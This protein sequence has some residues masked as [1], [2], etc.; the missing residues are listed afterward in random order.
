LLSFCGKWEVIDRI[1]TLNLGVEQ[2]SEIRLRAAIEQS[3]YACSDRG[4]TLERKG[5]IFSAARRLIGPTNVPTES[6]E[7]ALE[8]A[9]NET[10][11]VLIK[12]AG[13]NYLQAPGMRIME[14]YCAQYINNA[15]N[16]PTDNQRRLFIQDVDSLI[17]EFEEIEK[18]ST[19]CPDFQLTNE[20]RKA[21]KISFQNRFSV[22][23]GGAG[24]GK[25]TV[26][27]ALYFLMDTIGLPRFQM[28]LSGM[29][30]ARMT[31]ATHE[32]ATTIAK[33]LIA[34]S[35][36][37]MGS[38]PIII[39][40]ECSMV[41]IS[42]FYRILNKV[43][44]EAH[45]VMVGDP[46]Q[47]PPI[48]AGLVL[49]CLYKIKNI[50]LT[51]LKVVK[52]QSKDSGILE[53]ASSVRLGKVPCITSVRSEDVIWIH[54]AS[55]ESGL[56][57]QVLELYEIDKKNTQILSATKTLNKLIN[58]IAHETYTDRNNT[59]DFMNNR[60]DRMEDSGFRLDDLIMF[61]KNDWQRDIQNGLLGQIVEVYNSPR[62][63]DLPGEERPAVSYGKALV[64]KT[65]VVELTERELMFLSHAYSITV[66]KSQG[67]QFRRVIVPL[68]RSKLLDRT[69]I[70]TAI[71]RATDKVV[72]IGDKKEFADS[73][74]SEPHAFFRQVG[75]HDLLAEH[76]TQKVD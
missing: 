3:V 62:Q 75:L 6:L 20:Q 63:L 68:T 40:D 76:G 11:V 50:P 36:K 73:V 34:A 67:N 42:L 58:R 5:K 47:L 44:P 51:E 70:Y 74:K 27:K 54:R 12:G 25:T 48:G 4:H 23:T 49:H 22:I 21:I 1:A 16:S 39:I 10:Q 35:K 24:V 43:P 29:A 46:Y 19:K 64:G 59:I 56:L 37:E 15:L 17:D 53:V 9:V 30:A 66:H 18:T 32:K 14:Q 38:S 55:S 72:I 7:R 33:F 71:T 26:L 57:R 52:R 60:S 41:D 45:I 28:A 31:E 8:V 65:R 61:T 2:L 69:L 13:S